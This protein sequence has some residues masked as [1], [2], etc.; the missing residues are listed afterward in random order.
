MWIRRCPDAHR[1]RGH[2]HRIWPSPRTTSRQR[3]RRPAVP[4][5]H[6]GPVQRHGRTPADHRLS[7][8]RRLRCPP[9]RRHRLVGA[10]S[11]PTSD[12]MLV[13]TTCR[14]RTFPMAVRRARKGV[15]GFR[16]PAAS[17][18]TS[19][20]RIGRPVP[21]EPA[22]ATTK[23]SS[24]SAP[25]AP[26]TDA[27]TEGTKLLAYLAP[28]VTVS[29]P[30]AGHHQNQTATPNCRRSTPQATTPPGTG[31]LRL[32]PSAPLP[33]QLREPRTSRSPTTFRDAHQRPARHPD[34]H[35]TCARRR[36]C[37]D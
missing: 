35:A 10:G 5:H 1:L 8:G 14:G 6:R 12:S 20:P 3:Q 24:T 23:A 17:P 28:G 9:G 16:I 32:G 13:E 33:K 36:A 30:R 21:G 4:D 26:G 37:R 15:G 29:N 31:A 27:I 2:L 25:T 22:R 11:V 18:Q 7:L 19:L 34:A